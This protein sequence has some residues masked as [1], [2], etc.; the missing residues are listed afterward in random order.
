MLGFL[1]GAP[2]PDGTDHP[3][4]RDAGA[5]APPPQHPQVQPRV[6]QHAHRVPASQG[7]R[8]AHRRRGIKGMFPMPVDLLYLNK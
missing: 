5:A 7:H 6:S 4:Q 1:Q 8:Q 3:P 2:E